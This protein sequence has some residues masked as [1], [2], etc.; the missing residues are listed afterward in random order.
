M[1]NCSSTSNCNPCGPD[2]SAINQLATKTGAYARQANTYAVNA[3]NSW[4]EFNALYLG[5][6]AVAPTVDNE[7][8]PL[9]TGALYW[10]TALTQLFAWSGTSWVATN[11]NEFTPFLA[12]G[13]TNA[14]NLV[15]RE[16]DVVNVKDFG[17]V[18]DGITDD[19][20]AFQSFLNAGGGSI[21]AG[22]YSVSDL[23]IPSNTKIWSFKNATIRARVG[24]TRI[25]SG[26]NASDVSIEGLTIDGNAIA[27]DGIYF[28]G[29][30]SNRILI[31]NN[32]I[33]GVTINAIWIQQAK[34]TTVTQ[35]TILQ[36]GGHGIVH[37]IAAE[38]FVISNN[39]IEDPGYA[40]IIFSQGNFGSITGNYIKN[41][42]TFGDNIT[43]YHQFNSDITITGNVCDG[44]QNHGIH[45][46]GSRITVTGNIVLNSLQSG[47]FISSNVGGS[48]TN[49]QTTSNE[50]IVTGNVIDTTINLFPIF[51]I[52]VDGGVIASNKT[53]GAAQA[54]IHLRN[55]DEVNVIGNNIIGG[56]THG[57]V[58][59]GSRKCTVQSNFIDSPAQ[60]CVRVE[61][62]TTIGSTDNFILE[63]TGIGG[64]TVFAEAVN[65]N[66][67]NFSR[68]I[69]TGY[70]TQPFAKTG[71]LT[72]WSLG[73]PFY[74]VLPSAAS[75]GLVGWGD[76]F[77][78]TGTTTITT[79]V[80]ANA[81]IG[82]T[83]TL[84]F[85]GAITIQN[86]GVIKLNGGSN[87]TAASGNTLTLLYD[88]TN[89]VEVSRGTA[90]S[91]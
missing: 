12:T 38:R 72:T 84:L 9:Q 33:Q 41:G 82:R 68:N 53:K 36:P 14:R 8:D 16:A 24:T 70:S 21:P 28:Q 43:G 47:I 50:V 37:T 90:T 56:A 91:P 25:F 17:A 71:S 60:N 7:G 80:I 55:C 5:A 78:I 46:G 35:N 87:F 18:G 39:L 42:G 22:I 67:N 29:A 52:Q 15:T 69:A 76:V 44:S 75:L 32:V 13:T 4:L 23:T 48:S 45:V 34:Y 59:G 30:S 27:Q 6:F 10:N 88:G 49:P 63:N 2:F 1:G 62:W 3:E 73:Q 54:N 85:K 65:C 81:W 66:N 31:T 79:I 20:A 61:Q 86:A 40:G 26:N 19:T 11:F 51:F 83:I 77:E 74:D 57:V 64:T 58:I 89:F